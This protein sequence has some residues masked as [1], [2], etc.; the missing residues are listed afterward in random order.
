[1]DT[2]HTTT[3]DISLATSGAHLALPSLDASIEEVPAADL[4]EV[5][6]GTKPVDPPKSGCNGV[7]CGN[8]TVTIKISL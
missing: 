6:G 3:L 1:M 7:T 8:T 4:D 2:K 5:A